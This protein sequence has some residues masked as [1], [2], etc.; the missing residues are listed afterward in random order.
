MSQSKVK[1]IAHRGNV[2]GREADNENKPLYIRRALDAGFDAEVDV[3]RKGKYWFLGHDNPQ[4]EV[5]SEFLFTKGLWCHAK[6]GAALARMILAGVRIECFANDRDPYTLTSN[7]Y[8]WTLA[9]EIASAYAV[10]VFRKNEKPY[11]PDAEICYAVCCDTVGELKC[12]T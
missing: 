3:W 5:S 10:W 2:N 8:I 6:N 12:S 11:I 4:Y 9:E 1:L 7:G